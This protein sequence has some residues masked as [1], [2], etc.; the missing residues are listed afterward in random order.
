ML[1]TREAIIFFLTDGAKKEVM[2][3]LSV[4]LD[5]EVEQLKT[6]LASVNGQLY[7]IIQ[8]LD[9]NRRVVVLIYGVLFL[10]FFL[11]SSVWL[12]F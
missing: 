6:K 4:V 3:L 11:F 2:L 9:L 1:F 12:V 8:F 10:F 7:I 5:S